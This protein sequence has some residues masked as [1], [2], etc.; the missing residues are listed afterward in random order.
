MAKRRED[1]IL[2][3]GGTI[4]AIA[5]AVL[6]ADPDPREL[7]RAAAFSHLE[8]RDQVGASVRPAR[9]AG[10]VTGR[11]VPV[12]PPGSAMVPTV[13]VRINTVG[14]GTLVSLIDPIGPLP[15]S[16][17]HAFATVTGGWA[18]PTRL[19]GRGLLIARGIAYDA[20]W[21]D[22]QPD[23][24]T[25][26]LSSSNLKSVTIP[27]ASPLRQLPD[28]HL[29]LK[30]PG[31]AVFVLFARDFSIDGVPVRSV[32]L[33]LDRFE[34]PAIGYNVPDDGSQDM[35]TDHPPDAASG[36][37]AAGDGV[38]TRVLSGLSPGR[39]RYGFALNGDGKIRRDAYEET[40]DDS[41]EFYRSAIDVRP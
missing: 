22:F 36:D 10:V 27:A 28:N 18:I 16:S 25:G 19:P 12:L 2:I 39:H 7:P 26:Q 30:A 35:Q 32:R 41:T 24:V 33:L 37:L 14:T 15:G 5:V 31:R 29:L 1:R 34:N 21:G 3:L 38:F 4:L 20:G 11:I 23:P 8:P 17:E 6:R 13:G 40:R 9:A